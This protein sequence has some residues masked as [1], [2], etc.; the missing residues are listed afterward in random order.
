M[1]EERG[2]D[3]HIS[4]PIPVWS[5]TQGWRGRNHLKALLLSSRRN[6]R[7]EWGPGRT[8]LARSW[9]TDKEVKKMEL[10][11]IRRRSRGARL[12][13]AVCG[14]QAAR[15]LSD[16]LPNPSLCGTSLQVTCALRNGLR[17]S[18]EIFEQLKSYWNC[19]SS[20]CLQNW[21]LKGAK[22]Q[23]R[24]PRFSPHHPDHRPPDGSQVSPSPWCCHQGR[25]GPA[26]WQGVIAH[27]AVC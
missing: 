12:I 3:T 23:P 5:H 15:H 11:R 21:T 7:V 22:P 25:R 2:A 14:L 9:R 13:T 16:L 27:C 6:W 26:H 4:L 18:Q 19:Y 20:P 24:Y 8:E 10:L 17:W 1:R